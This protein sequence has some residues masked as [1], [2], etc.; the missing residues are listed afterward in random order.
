MM[1]HKPKQ[2]FLSIKRTVSS[3]LAVI[4]FL[5]PFGN[6][7]FAATSESSPWVYDTA[8]VVSYSGAGG[9][10][11]DY[12]ENY[13]IDLPSG[14]NGLT[15]SL[16]LTYSSQSSG[17]GSSV[18]YGWSLSIPSVTRL[19]K[20]GVDKMYSQSD[21]YSSYDGELTEVDTNEYIPRVQTGGFR[22][23]TR[24]TD[25]WITYSPEGSKY[26]FGSS[27]NA[28]QKPHSTSTDT[29]AWYLNEIQDSNGNKVVYEYIQSQG[30]VYPSKIFYGYDSSN[31]NAY[32]VRF[33]YA[34]SSQ[35]VSYEPGFVVVND[36]VVESIEVYF[37]SSLVTKYEF[38]YENSTGSLINLLSSVQKIGYDENNV[39]DS[40]SPRFFE[41]V[42]ES[43]GW[44][45]DETIA[46][47][48]PSHLYLQVNDSSQ[49]YTQYSRDMLIDM[50]GDGL[51][52]WV[53]GDTVYLNTG[54][55]WESSSSWLSLPVSDIHLEN[56][57]VDVNGDLLPD[58]VMSYDTI[59]DPQFNGAYSNVY[60]REVWLNQGNGEWITSS[61]WA[62]TIPTTIYTKF[63]GYPGGVTYYNNDVFF[64]D[65]NGDGLNDWLYNGYVYLNEGTGWATTS[66]WARLASNGE[67]FSAKWRLSDVNSDGLPDLIKSDTVMYDP[68]LTNYDD[69]YT[70]EVWMNLG[71]G[72]WVRNSTWEETF[73]NDFNSRFHIQYWN[74]PGGITY[75]KNKV[76][77][78]DVNGDGLNDWIY[79]NKALLN[80]GAGWATSSISLPVSSEDL[81][82]SY[83]L[84]DL[85]GDAQLDFVRH[86]Y[87]YFFGT[88]THTKEALINSTQKQWLLSTTT[89]EY[90]GVTTIT[91]DVTTEE[92]GGNLLNPDS[93]IV[94]Y[95]VS[96]V[97]KNPLI[98][99]NVTT[100]FTYKG[101][102]F[103]FS[104]TTPFDRKFA[105]FESVTTETPINKVKTYYH[106]GNDS[107]TSS[108]ESNDHYSKITLPY[109]TEVYNL[110]DDLYEVS[111]I[112][113]S[114][115][116][117]ATSSDFVK[118]T[119]EVTLRYD[120]D[121]DRRDAA[122][123]FSYDDDTG[124]TASKIEYGEVSASLD[125]SYGDAG[126]DKRTTEYEYA[127]S[128][129]YNILGLL[130]KETIKDNSDIK[131][132]ETRYYYDNQSLG[133]VINGNLTKQED[134]VSASS[135]V[136]RE[137]TYNS[138]GLVTSGTDP[139]EKVTSYEYD[140]YDLYVSSTTNA[141]GHN[142][143]YE[144]D[145]SSG[146]VA[147][148]TDANGEIFVTVYDGFDRPVE[149]IVP[150]SQ[151]GNLVTQTT[152]VYTDTPGAV[153][154]EATN[155]LTPSLTNTKYSYL[156]GFGK[157]IQERVE[158]EDTNEFSVKDYVY[159][160]SGL[161]HKESLPYFGNGTARTA[162]TTDSDILNVFTYDALSRI[163]SVET[164]VGT[165]YREYDQWTETITDTANND[166]TLEYDAYGRLVQV[167][168]EEGV[169][170][171]DTTY[172]WNAR[173]DLV[174]ITDANGNVRN[175]TYDAL[176]R[177]T[178]LEDVHDTSDGTY[179]T[180]QFSYD[181][182][183]NKNSA[184]DPR[185]QVVNYTYDDINR[186]LTED[187]VGTGYTDIVYGYDSCTYG[188]ARLCSVRN[189]NATTTYSYTSNGLSASESKTVLGTTYTTE[190]EYDRLGNQTLIV[191]PDA[192]EVKYTYNKANKVEKVEQREAA[193]SFTEI[194]NDFDYGPHGMVTYQK[195]GNDSETT[196][197]Y[198]ENELYRLRSIETAATSTYGT[199]GPGLELAL[200][201]QEIGLLASESE[202]EAVIEETVE[203]NSQDVIVTEDA[204]VEIATSTEIIDTEIVEEP[205]EEVKKD[206]EI[207]AAGLVKN[208]QE[209]DIW[210]R[211]HKE[212]VE[213]L[214]ANK[215]VGGEVVAAAE[216]AQEKYELFLIDE[217]YIKRST[218]EISTLSYDVIHFFTNAFKA[219]VRSV[220]PKQ[221][222]AYLF[223]KEDFESC[224]SL[225]CSLDASLG[226][227]SVT[228]SIDNTGMIE[229]DD[230]LRAVVTGAG[231]GSIETVGYNTTEIWSQFKIYI[232]SSFQWGTSGFFTAF[233]IEDPSNGTLMWMSV[234]DY[235]TPRLT[236][237]GDVLGYTNTGLNLTEGAVNTIEIRVKTGSGT[238]DVDIWL[239]SSTEGSPSYNGSGT[240]NLGTDNIADILF[241]MHYVPENGLST[242]YYDE[243]I[244][245]NA[246]I[247]ATTSSSSPSNTAPSAPTS[248]QV[249]GQTNPTNISDPTPE[250]SAI[251]NDS[252]DG[253]IATKFKLQ[254]STSS[255]F[256][257]IYWDSGTTS[258]AS[259]TE[260]NRSSDVTYGGSSLASSTIY[261]WRIKFWDDE[262]AEGVWS[263]ETA[264][265]SLA[266]G[267]GGGSGGTSTTTLSIYGDSLASGWD[268]WS[269]SGTYDTSATGQVYEGTYSLQATYSS[270]YGGL[271]LRNGS[272]NTTGYN[273]L[274]FGFYLSSGSGV[275][276]Q[277]RGVNKTTNTDLGY[278][279]L[280][281]YLPGG[282]YT[283]GQWYQV[284]V[285]LS[286]L[287]L[288]DFNGNGAIIWQ[289]NG[290]PTVV[291]YYDDIKLVGTTTSSSSNAAPTAPSSLQTDGQTNPTNI[292][293]P[294]PEFSAI[295]NDPDSGDTALFY[296][297]QVDDNSD[298]SSVYWNSTKTALATTTQGNRSPD[299]SYAGSSLAS[300]TTYYWRIKFW[301][302]EDAEGAWSTDT[303]TFNL[304]TD[305]STTTFPIFRETVQNLTYT[306]DS[307][308]NI[309][310]IIDASETDLAVTTIYDYD[311]LYR[312]TSASTTG[313]SSTP[314]THSYTY[315]P[316]GNILTKSDVGSYTYAETNYANPH[317]ATAIAGV[318]QTYDNNGNL[319]STSDGTIYTWN[320]RNQLVQSAEG[321][322]STS[323]GY[324]HTGTRV[325]KGTATATTTYPSSLYEA[326]GTST[327]KHI[328]ANDTLV[329]TIESAT[330]A[331][332]IYYVY[333]NHLDST[334]VVLGED[335]YITQELAYYPYGAT[336][337]D[338]Q[339]GPYDELHRFTG[340]ELDKETDLTYAGARYYDHNIGRWISMDPASRDNPNQFLRDPQQFNTYSYARNNPLVLFDPT[341]EKVAEFQPYFSSGGSYA[342]GDLLGTYRGTSIYSGGSL[343]GSGN[344][345]YQCVSFCKQ[346]ASSEYGVNLG[347][348]GNG[349]D[350]GNQAN[351]DRSFAANNSGNP[352]RYAAYSNGGNVMPQENDIISWSG[353]TYGHV[354]VIAEVYFNSKTNSGMVYSLEQNA[355]KDQAL[356]SQPFSR[357]K[358]GTYTVSGR[359]SYSVQGW[360]RYEN[361]SM[362]PG[363]ESYSTDPMTPATKK[364]IKRENN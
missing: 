345:S 243:F 31:N 62:D 338:N 4:L 278:A 132:K 281:T 43:V 226:W 85:D 205:V 27:T 17:Y 262:D 19:N 52:D 331:P 207:I 361:Q 141:V 364:P 187:Y 304:V 101:G 172:D 263:T 152:Y 116:S 61:S 191:Y 290:S 190:Y 75:Y 55:G 125:G 126:S 77:L 96:E 176:S 169:S 183:G 154:I 348:T 58:I 196:K 105:G 11:G 221:V 286:A 111:V 115:E 312:L 238:G 337:I 121:G 14:A 267:G 343:T 294:T 36:R 251:Y 2:S 33:V 153:R 269:Y 175:L 12:S 309:T 112:D 118:K 186:I 53:E 321:G 277:M 49:N 295:Y 218:D 18:G 315:S 41:Y 38:E 1:Y 259:T 148:T 242:T 165:M 241:G 95:V 311:D 230:S 215:D 185:G 217:G 212:R 145:Y 35:Y 139:K 340:H 71:T 164:S 257:T 283:N 20:N 362:M 168:E 329:A 82:K 256:S 240:M 78:A 225:P 322:Q 219:L 237:M 80:T 184:T 21:F 254:V 59:Y 8:R 7:T 72:D 157:V 289:S 271:Q 296:Q 202:V 134:W 109:R 54:D 90:G 182:V 236:V 318:T 22:M 288:Q 297:I 166:K 341:G 275:N 74:Y 16:E 344:H 333:A 170:S 265:F 279:N 84:V 313:A 336:R 26:T 206:K 194:V 248:L 264:T 305:S 284:S 258:M 227:G 233:K 146:K 200:I 107:A 177:R 300:S 250:F 299:I 123:A 339:Y 106:Q 216:Y 97:I 198:D 363:S 122:V 167:T 108:Y 144:Y 224:G 150:D 353:G 270:Q 140:S 23:Y 245:D 173:G 180:W 347:G 209:A 46:T 298:F 69:S 352:G 47:T 50:N 223:D 211:Y 138:L 330:P 335:G 39:A 228:N 28:L 317:A 29:H 268:N 201:E 65:M 280:S 6:L 130:S 171:Y 178:S 287:G 44:T 346:F 195:N 174:K 244:V 285:P 272:L 99:D 60:N 56:R 291:A 197:T 310:Q 133:S 301:D 276:I 13:S 70:N 151:T 222:Y 210:R 51:V 359:G 30:K 143:R 86:L 324:D 163:T 260:G 25:S 266:A 92:M 110:N 98:G 273:T 159:G 158:A 314:Y 308:G 319:A 231:G 113:Y 358:D 303:A 136:D 306:Y 120:G 255:S 246:F 293:D 320:Y 327:K 302:D 76:Y 102:D 261:Y 162:A 357:N 88:V 63:W 83:R 307:I 79:S 124:L 203:I 100:N 9:Q 229:G 161:M 142:T 40:L 155:Y 253:D 93:P 89:D 220:L 37:D 64:V 323:Y 354:G 91:Y 234:E 117:L 24:S 87:K 5:A 3:I 114:L 274:D 103:Y 192:S 235:G 208:S 127:S 179:G 247:G 199:G 282:T 349:V 350:Y 351:L 15:P 149:V 193:G 66:E 45:N 160:D 81:V 48:T 249:E 131:V 137:W 135:Y 356:F 119:D 232:P 325:Y 57:L 292:T 68:R 239:N 147:T 213:Y 334:N 188:I 73:P 355:K 316:I 189:E 252:D 10:Y 204:S 332:D 214:K 181:A 326:V 328:Y 104:S 32:E 129:T 42:Q 156:D 67:P 360:A 342:I 94:Q 128:A 34:S